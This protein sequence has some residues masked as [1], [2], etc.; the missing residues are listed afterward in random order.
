MS[1]FHYL[2]EYNRYLNIIG[3][4]VII[5]IALLFSH[6]R[7]AINIKL[8]INALVLQFILGFGVLK[9]SVGKAI[10]GALAYGA[11]TMYEFAEEGINFVFGG[12]ADPQGRGDLF[13]P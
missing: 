9:T 5:A 13:L 3:I 6:K 12:L 1:L 4:G 2:M 8:I 7:S 11:S 10:V